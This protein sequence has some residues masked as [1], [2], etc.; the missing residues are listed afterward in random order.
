MDGLFPRTFV[1]HISDVILAESWCFD[2]CCLEHEKRLRL[3]IAFTLLKS[4]KD[5]GFRGIFPCESS[6]YLP[7]IYISDWCQTGV[8]QNPMYTQS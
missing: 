1:V 4:H 2:N 7:V 5:C 3:H 6:I 8:M